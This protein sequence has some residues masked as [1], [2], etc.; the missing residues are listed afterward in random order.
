MLYVFLVSGVIE[1]AF[2]PSDPDVRVSVGIVEPDV[3][4]LIPDLAPKVG[5]HVAALGGTHPAKAEAVGDERAIRMVV[6]GGAADVERF[7]EP[8]SI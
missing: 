1:V 6:D 2:N 5:V 7:V 8:V 4:D 3:I